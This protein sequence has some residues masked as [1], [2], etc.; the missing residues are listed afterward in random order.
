MALYNTSVIKRV[1]IS[2]GHVLCGDEL[3]VCR[4]LKANLDGPVWNNWNGYIVTAM[5]AA[6]FDDIP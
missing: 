3:L 1:F 4:D 2:I 5:V 6:G